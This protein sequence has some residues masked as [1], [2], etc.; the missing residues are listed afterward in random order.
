MDQALAMQLPVSTS[1]DRRGRIALYLGV[2]LALLVLLALRLGNPNLIT[3]SLWAEDGRIFMEQASHGLESVWTVYA[4][5]IHLYPRLAALIARAAPLLSTP[6]IFNLAWLCAYLAAAWALLHYALRHT[7]SP[8]VAAL[9]C[10][11]FTNR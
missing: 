6:L 4:G 3:A 11:A 1:L 9:L 2:T 5:Y 10:L 7:D 8:L